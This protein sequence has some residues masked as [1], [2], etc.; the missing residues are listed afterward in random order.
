MKRLSHSWNEN[1]CIW[2]DMIDSVVVIQ[3]LNWPSHT[4]A[5]MFSTMKNEKVTE[6]AKQLKMQFYDSFISGVRIHINHQLFII[7]QH[8][9]RVC[10]YGFI[11]LLSLPDS[12]SR[13][14]HNIICNFIILKIGIV[15]LHFSAVST[16]TLQTH[17]F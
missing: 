15:N 5:T 12:E 17:L 4:A 6:S 7:K 9:I 1:V 14:F 13:W 16:M 10:C 8:I 11:F 2:Q 3:S